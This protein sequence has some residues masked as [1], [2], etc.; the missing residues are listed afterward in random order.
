[1]AI[2]EID[3]TEKEADDDKLAE[4]MMVIKETLCTILDKINIIG[5]VFEY[6]GNKIIQIINT[7]EISFLKDRSG[8]Y[9]ILHDLKL[10]VEKSYN[11]PVITAIGD[12]HTDN[13]AIRDSFGEALKALNYKLLTG[14]SEI[15]LY[16]DIKARNVFSY[17]YP[18]EMES[19]LIQSLQD[20]DYA[21]VSCFLDAVLEENFKKKNIDF[22]VAKCL[23]YDL[24]ATALKAIDKIQL[25]VFNN[26]V[27]THEL[28]NCSTFDGMMVYIRKLYNNICTIIEEKKSSINQGTIFSIINDIEK[29]YGQYNLSLE[30]MAQ[31]YNM[32]KSS[33]S[34]LF[35]DRTG[36][37]YSDY[38]SRKRIDKAKEL[39]Q[40]SEIS[41][42]DIAE[43]VGFTNDITF[44]RT[45]KK[46]E[47][48]TPGEYRGRI[49]KNK[50]I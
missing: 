21:K 14:N 9:N 3:S 36:F 1:V 16:S 15:I 22:Y 17:Y 40:K 4:I 49:R 50:A 8:L 34:R 31:K 13:Y 19:Q 44:R 2:L 27:I 37:Y 42:K 10:N 23:F 47:L 7:D 43:A 6:E 25:A 26:G 32:S 30:L 41:I 29:E 28:A 12:I 5:Q 46:Y 38:I 18:I 48:L 11:I 39:L 33:L 24:E 20:G 45:F 35:K